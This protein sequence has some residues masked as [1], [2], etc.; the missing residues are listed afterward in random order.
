M[1]DPRSYKNTFPDVSWS[2]T[3]GPRLCSHTPRLGLRWL[4]AHW[5]P[6]EISL[7]IHLRTAKCISGLFGCNARWSPWN[8]ETGRNGGHQCS[9]ARMAPAALMDPKKILA[10]QMN[11][12]GHRVVHQ[13]SSHHILTWKQISAL[14]WPQEKS[15]CSMLVILS[16]KIRVVVITSKPS[17][18]AA[19]SN[20]PQAHH[21]LRDW[22]GTNNSASILEVRHLL[23]SNWVITL[24]S[25][26]H[27][28]IGTMIL[29]EYLV[30]LMLWSFG[31]QVKSPFRCST[32]MDRF[33]SPRRILGR[34]M[35]TK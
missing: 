21:S 22:W 6:G 16:Q 28:F 8:L 12:C 34:P 29:E 33:G 17:A 19:V 11:R 18:N 26:S 25:T 27:C 23:L 35:R 5:N 9:D 13:G 20:N 32:P 3:S 24:T 15:V 14:Q 2:R 4:K 7:E 30:P 10:N 31:L 1:F